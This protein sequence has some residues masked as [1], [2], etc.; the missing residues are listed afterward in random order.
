MKPSY[1][2]H[3]VKQGSREWWALHL[4]IPTASSFSRIITPA[5]LDY[6]KGAHGYAAELIAERILGRPLDWGVDYDTIWTE[7]GT[8]M[9]EDARDWY[10]LYRG[11]EVEAVGFVTVWE[12]TVGGSPDGLVGDD[13]I[14]EIKCRRAAAHAKCMMGI[15]PTAG[16]LQT[17]GYL[18]LTDR[19]WV[20][21][22]AYNDVL[23]KRI[24][25]V[26][27]DETVIDAIRGHL[28]KFLND[29]EKAEAKLKELG[30]VIEDDGL[31]QALAASVKKGAA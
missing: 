3:D 7:R 21:V 13:G 14:V 8:N 10:A 18:W 16:H 6:S 23:P 11:V 28:G 20:D 26:H 30:D 2:I 27:R 5:K 24:D 19:Q 1:E 15:D 12:R 22:I 9:E 17:Q 31:L 25:R 29:M 4:G